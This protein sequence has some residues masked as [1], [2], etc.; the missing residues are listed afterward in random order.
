MNNTTTLD[1]SRPERTVERTK[2]QSASNSKAPEP[3]PMHAESC[4][5]SSCAACSAKIEWFASVFET[6]LFYLC[7]VGRVVNRLLRK[8]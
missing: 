7:P 1:L 4:W 5:R 8:R 6:L 2:R 3:G